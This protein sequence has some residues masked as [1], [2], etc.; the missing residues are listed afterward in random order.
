MS[1]FVF[2]HILPFITIEVFLRLLLLDAPLF[3]SLFKTKGKKIKIKMRT[4]EMRKVFANKPEVL[5]FSTS[6]P[7]RHNTAL[8]N[9]CTQ[10]FY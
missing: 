5:L 8:C 9:I 3:L 1:L 6:Q 2:S 4:K 10:F 7:H